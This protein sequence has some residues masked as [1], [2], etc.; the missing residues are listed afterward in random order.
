MQQDAEAA[1]RIVRL[2]KARPRGM[3]ISEISRKLHITRNTVA[4]HLGGLQL[5][6]RVEL[7]VIGNAKVYRSAQRI[8]ISSFLKFTKD[9]ILVLDANQR[10]VQANDQLLTAFGW[11]MEEIQGRKIEDLDIPPTFPQEWTGTSGGLLEKE[12][13]IPHLEYRTGGQSIHYRAKIIPVVFEHGG[14]GT[15][16]ILEDITQAY[17]K[18]QL[19]QLY[20]HN[21]EFLARAAMKFIRLKDDEELYAVIG[22]GMKELVPTGII[23]VKIFNPRDITFRTR[24]V[25]GVPSRNG[26]YR[27]IEEELIGVTEKA[28]DQVIRDL[29]DTLTLHQ[30]EID[31]RKVSSLFEFFQGEVSEKICRAIE[32]AFCIDKIYVGGLIWKGSLYGKVAILL[33]KDV[34]LRNEEIINQFLRQASMAFQRRISEARLEQAESQIR[35]IADLIPLPATIFSPE[36]KCLYLNRTFSE[37]FGYSI[38]DMPLMEEFFSSLRDPQAGQVLSGTRQITQED[39]GSGDITVRMDTIACRDQSMKEILFSTLVLENFNRFILCREG[40][41]PPCS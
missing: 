12:E 6:G 10:V 8:P 9:A 26:V 23:L 2:L 39:P 17:E 35:K 24:L 30:P 36:G 16:V 27:M 37:W 25:K 7:E 34:P 38:D 33:P 28:H 20:A 14:K 41:S 1:E 32:K 11:N 18:E 40:G 4:K 5:A 13:V 31:G 29:T 3:T 19:E 15:T 22:E 21:M